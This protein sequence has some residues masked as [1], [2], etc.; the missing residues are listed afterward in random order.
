MSNHPNR[1]Q[2]N[3]GFSAN[4]KPAEIQRAR[5]AAGLTQ[6]Q[7]GELVHSALKS[8]QNW[9]SDGQDNRRMHPATWELFNVK[10]RAKKLLETGQVTESIV[11]LFGIYLP[12]Q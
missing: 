2:T 1:S 5:E 7:A 3:R 9:E 4:P 12:K 11:K 8:W 6:T 10:V